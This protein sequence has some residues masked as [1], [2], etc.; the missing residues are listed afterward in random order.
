MSRVFFDRY[1]RLRGGWTA[2]VVVVL[3]VAAGVALV[4][5]F[6]IGMTMANGASCERQGDQRG[7]EAVYG[8]WLDNTCYVRTE[9]GRVLTIDQYD[10]KRHEVTING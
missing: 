10:I 9:D 3:V 7:V 8:G 1:G 6:I 4:S 5:P 2:A